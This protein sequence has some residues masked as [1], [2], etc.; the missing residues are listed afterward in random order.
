MQEIAKAPST[1]LLCGGLWWFLRS[2][3]APLVVCANQL[4]TNRACADQLMKFNGPPRGVRGSATI[5]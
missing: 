3:G 4:V 1:F 2:V 5:P